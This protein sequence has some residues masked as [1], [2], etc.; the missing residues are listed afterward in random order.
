MNTICLPATTHAI[1]EAALLI[2]SGEIVAFPTETVYGLG[3]DT[4]NPDAI[5]KIFN[6][7]QRPQDNPLIVHIADP[8]DISHLCYMEHTAKT[9]IEFFFP[10]PLTLV[11]RKKDIIPDIITAG[12]DSVAIRMP[13][14]PIAH[15]F[16]KTTGV[17]IAAPSANRSGKPSPTTA[18]HV[19]T[20]LSGRIP[21]VLDGGECIIGIES[22]VLDVRVNPPVILRPGGVTKE[23]LDAVVGSVRLSPGIM[24]PLEGGIPLPSPGMRH[25]HYTPNGTLTLFRGSRLN[26]F[27]AIKTEYDKTVSMG[28]ASAIFAFTPDIRLFGDRLVFSMGNQ[29]APQET[30]KK[31]YTLLRS[32]DEM[33]I[34]CIYS[35]IPNLHDIGM[36]V[37]NRL[38]RAARFN[39]IDT[40]EEVS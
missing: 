19:I 1:R 12:L 13:S 16:I 18:A 11:M 31:L 14:H 28:Y 35:T 17:P 23:S 26:V 3:A 40:G 5:A 36:G 9:L 8:C 22:T 38:I 20:D 10:G 33:G 15:A 30:A 39:I 37:V 2:Q 29:D 21:M 25:E 27:K 7:K 24:N 34:S 6:A 32:M 4:F